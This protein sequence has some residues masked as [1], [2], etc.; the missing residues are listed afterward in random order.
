MF[1]DICIKRILRSCVLFCI[2]VMVVYLILGICM[3]NYLFFL[4]REMKNIMILSIL[5]DIKFVFFMLCYV[6]V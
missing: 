3:E 4:N 1:K 5:V 6:Y 2:K